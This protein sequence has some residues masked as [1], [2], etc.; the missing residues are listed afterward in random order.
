MKKLNK[1]TDIGQYREVVQYI[2]G[3][4]QYIGKNS[5]GEPM[6]DETIELPSINFNGTCKLHGT[7]C[8]V[9]LN[10]RGD[11][12]PQSREKLLSI[13]EDNAGFALFFNQKKSVFQKLFSIIDFNGYDFITIFGEWCGK[14][15]QNKVA[16]SKLEKMFVIFDIKL[17]YYDNTKDKNIYLPISEIKKIRSNEDRI[18]NIYDFETFDIT[19]DFNKPEDSLD[20]LIE[21]TNYVENNCPVGRSFGVENPMGE[22]IVWSYYDNDGNKV[23]FKTKGKYHKGTSSKKRIVEVDVEKINNIKEFVDYAVTEPRLNQGLEKV[24]GFN[25][26]LDIKKLGDFIRWVVNDIMKEETDTLTKNGL[27]QK[28]VNSSI[29]IVSRNWFLNKYNTF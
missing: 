11:M 21:L 26:P 15:I 24:F 22:G 9:T 23:R 1:Y 8:S 12:Y 13:E 29:S 27:I 18:F 25:Q 19:I 7:N 14:G 2:K 3:R 28:D 5:D 17:S 6:F 20:K 10:T 16:V 4:T